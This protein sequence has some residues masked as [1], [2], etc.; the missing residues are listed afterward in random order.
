MTIR[1]TII[2]SVRQVFYTTYAAFPTTGLTNGDLAWATDRK[3]FYIWTGSAWEASGISSRHGNYADIGD[4]A[5]YPESSL[6]QADDTGALYM[7]VTG[8]WVFIATSSSLFGAQYVV[9]GSRALTTVYQNTAGKPKLVVV[10]IDGY[11]SGTAS[12][13]CDSNASPTTV[14]SKHSLNFVSTH[15][16]YFVMFLIPVGYYYKVTCTDAS[17]VL[18]Y[19]VEYY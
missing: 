10:T 4:P 5:N 11:A 9:T 18:E 19:W 2:P 6:Y 14:V 13:Y 16:H 8:A 15:D 17:A 1:T 3:C 12:A 7:V